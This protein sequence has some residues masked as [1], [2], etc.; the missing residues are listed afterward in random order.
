MDAKSLP[1]KPERVPLEG[2]VLTRKL[3]IDGKLCVLM[4]PKPHFQIAR[5]LRAHFHP[6]TDR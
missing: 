1:D 6:T 4:A 5:V 3:V 2:R